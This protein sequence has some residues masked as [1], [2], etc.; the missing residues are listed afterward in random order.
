MRARTNR[1]KRKI[2]RLVKYLIIVIILSIV[3]INGCSRINFTAL[4]GKNKVYKIEK[5]T[6][7][8]SEAKFMLSVEK[9]LYDDFGDEVWDQKF[10]DSDF[11]DYIKL[12][13]KNQMGQ[14][15]SMLLFANDN[16]ISLSVSQKDKVK[17]IAKNYY[18][19][20]SDKQVENL[21][22]T[23]DT[24]ESIME[25]YAISDKVFKEFTNDVSSVI[26]DVD[27]KVIKVQHIFVKTFDLDHKGNEVSYDNEGKEVALKKAKEALNQAKTGDD[28]YA[29]AQKYSDDS[30]VEYS[31]SKGEM[32]TEFENAAFNLTEGEISDV[33]QSDKGF[34]IIKCL[35]SYMPEESV[36]K[37]AELIKKEKAKAFEKVY[38]PFVKNLKVS[39]NNSSWDKISIDSI[40][41]LEINPFV[42]FEENYKL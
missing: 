21:D 18:D 24:I 15:T 37:K 29:L 22:L 42:F 27:A 31:F 38:S 17:E 13:A 23:L 26:S 14:L 9:S 19:Y 39:F 16:D 4:L 2:K 5:E 8:L 41:N 36:V 12:K 35:S 1:K 11:E 20:L 34:Y 10:L 7:S 32:V 3:F 6:G 25:K 33:V 30:K 40:E 28:F